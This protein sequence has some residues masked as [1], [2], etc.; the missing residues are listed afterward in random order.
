VLRQYF[1]DS[2]RS[3]PRME[4]IVASFEHSV[5]RLESRAYTYLLRLS[6]EL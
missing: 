2:A 6:R 5:M 4:D 1:D 3:L